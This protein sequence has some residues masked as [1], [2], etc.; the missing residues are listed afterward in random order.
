MW[1]GNY[2]KCLVRGHVSSTFVFKGIEYKY[3][4]RCGRISLSHLTGIVDYPE[5]KSQSITGEK[6]GMIS[7]MSVSK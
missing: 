3:C 1:S 5:S 2:T 7:M 6:S 4:V